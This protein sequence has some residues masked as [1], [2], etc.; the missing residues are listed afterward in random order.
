MPR[1]PFKTRPFQA[2]F[3]TVDA[4]VFGRG[5][6]LDNG[7]I[8]E[9]PPSRTLL[10]KSDSVPDPAETENDLYALNSLQMQRTWPLEQLS[11]Q[12]PLE[13]L[14]DNLPPGLR[15]K[16]GIAM[17]ASTYVFNCT[18]EN[19]SRRIKKMYH[20]WQG[21]W[22]IFRN[23]EYVFWPI[24]AEKGYFV[25]AVFHLAKGVIDDP[26]FD[27]DEDPYTDI[28]QVENPRYNIVEGWSVVDAA[29]GNEIARHRVIRVKDRIQRILQAEGIIFNPDSYKG[30]NTSTEAQWGFPWVPPP[31]NGDEA[32][33]SGIRS[34]A[35]VR[36]LIQ[37]VLDFYCQ[38]QGY[39][40]SFFEDPTCGW[41]NVDQVRHEMMGICAM[42]VIEDMN[43]NARLSVEVIQHITTVE[44]IKP[45]STALLAPD[46]SAKRAY[47]PGS[48][49]HPMNLRSP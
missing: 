49:D 41:L 11:V 8:G 9:K 29:Q 34:F 6:I 25:T 24:Q 23:S 48:I 27:P 4:P 1:K 2:S 32:W 10:E 15:N 39:Q 33:S 40:D 30:D 47:V 18:E 16:I 5:T 28:P 45:F 12:I 38:E 36:Q 44:G 31:A 43:W 3:G 17:C 13:Y 19:V 37:R 21:F 7:L 42:N 20:K 14:R 26:D 46:N 35:L 22:D